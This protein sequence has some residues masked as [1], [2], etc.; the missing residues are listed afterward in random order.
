MAAVR[1]YLPKSCASAFF[2]S[3]KIKVIAAVLASVVIIF[4]FPLKSPAQEK[5]AQ[6]ILDRVDDL[7]RGDSSHGKM[8]MEITTEHWKRALTIELWS[9]GKEKSF[10]RVLSPKKER[11][12][13]TLRSGNNLW[14]FLPKIKRVIKLPSSM[15]ASSWM[16]SHFTN[17]DLVKESRMVDDYDFN[18]SFS[19]QRD[20]V[21]VVEITCTPKENAAVVWGKLVVVVNYQSMLP[22][23]ILYYDEDMVLARTMTFEDIGSLSGRRLPRKIIIKPED[24]PKESTVIIYHEL[25]FN[26]DLKDSL[27]SL[28]SLQR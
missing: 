3:H 2:Y 19:G 9:K 23:K 16:G 7:F 25:T 4:C 24:K 13:A 18:I 1:F 6:E 20:G 17:D 11:G 12:T 5:T 14:N 8:T 26:L 21:H 22:L 10:M 28:R 15:M 27:F